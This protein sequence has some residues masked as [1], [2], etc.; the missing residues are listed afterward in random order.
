MEYYLQIIPQPRARAR[1]LF[2]T[3]NYGSIFFI[4]IRCT[5]HQQFVNY[6]LSVIIIGY[7]FNQ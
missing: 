2:L 6:F 3:V 7:S 4:I 1:V 5:F